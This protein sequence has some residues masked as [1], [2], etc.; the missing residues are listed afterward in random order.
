M[1]EIGFQRN[2]IFKIFRGTMPPDPPRKVRLRR[3]EALR[4]HTNTLSKTSATRLMV[5]AKVTGWAFHKLRCNFSYFEQ[6]FALQAI[7]SFLQF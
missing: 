2:C 1:R 6:L 3:M 4:L 7:S 5:D